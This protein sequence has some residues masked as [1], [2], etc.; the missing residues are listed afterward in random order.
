MSKNIT[1]SLAPE[2][3]LFLTLLLT[4]TPSTPAVNVMVDRISRK[5][6]DAMDEAGV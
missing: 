4:A 5:M 3:T 2:E 6:L 1:I